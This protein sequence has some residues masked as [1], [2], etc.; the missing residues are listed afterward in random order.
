M[1]VGIWCLIWHSHINLI[2]LKISLFK[3]RL[4]CSLTLHARPTGIRISLWCAQSIA[5]CSKYAVMHVECHLR[6]VGNSTRSSLLPW[7][8]HPI[9]CCSISHIVHSSQAH[10]SHKRLNCLYWME[11]RL[12]SKSFSYFTNFNSILFRALLIW[13]A[14]MHP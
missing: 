2:C 6:F 11:N 5:F 9:V 14:G 8:L 1:I 12:K 3:L 7:N 10:S 4:L 13:I